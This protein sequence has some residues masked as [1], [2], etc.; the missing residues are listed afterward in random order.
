MNIVSAHSQS[1]EKKKSQW[2]L[3][4]ESA[5]ARLYARNAT[6]DLEGLVFIL[7]DFFFFL[8]RRIFTRIL[9]KHTTQTVSV[10]RVATRIEG[11]PAGEGMKIG[12]WM[13]IWSAG[14][15]F[16]KLSLGR[17]RASGH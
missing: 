14:G 15:L 4:L 11:I 2:P 6:K 5:R 12:A 10:D 16:C 13:D 17:G 3:C 9:W 7:K 8:I 1:V